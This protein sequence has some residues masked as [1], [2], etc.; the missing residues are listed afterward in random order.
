MVGALVD[1]GVL[2]LGIAQLVEVDF[3][4]DVGRFEIFSAWFVAT[5]E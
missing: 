3:L 1:E 4:I 2:L 5:V